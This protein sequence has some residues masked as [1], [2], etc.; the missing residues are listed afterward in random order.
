MPF[1]LRNSGKTFQRLMDGIINAVNEGMERK[2]VMAFVDDVAIFTH[3]AESHLTVVRKLLKVGSIEINPKKCQWLQESITFLGHTVTHRQ[4][5]CLDTHVDTIR[6]WPRPNNLK[7]LRRF[8]GFCGFYQQGIKNYASIA[9][10]LTELTKSKTPYEWTNARRLWR[11]VPTIVVF[12]CSRRSPRDFDVKKLS[13]VMFLPLPRNG[14]ERCQTTASVTLDD[15]CNS[16]WL[17]VLDP[18]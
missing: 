1:G 11:T 4:L 8:L 15:F 10:P 12:C 9:C 3:D 13:R 17:K 14:S 5:K 18:M 6:G 2:C 16:S 7:E